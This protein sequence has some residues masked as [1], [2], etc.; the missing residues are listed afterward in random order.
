MK[1]KIFISSTYSDLIPYREKIW[2]LLQGYNVKILG[3]EKFGARKKMLY[4]HALKKLNIQIFI[5]V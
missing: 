1:K 5:L 4:L 2:E 3:M